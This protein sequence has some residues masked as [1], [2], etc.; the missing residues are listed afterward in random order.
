MTILSLIIGTCCRPEKDILLLHSSFNLYDIW[1]FQVSSIKEVCNF[2]T[3][4]ILSRAK[5]NECAVVQYREYSVYYNTTNR[6]LGSVI[7]TDNEYPE[8]SS[9]KI[10]SKKYFRIYNKYRW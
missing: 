3:K 9:Q 4:F 10:T 2:A 8:K 7:V 1:F 6:G 5:E